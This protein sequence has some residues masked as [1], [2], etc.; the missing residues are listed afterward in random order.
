C[1]EVGLAARRRT[2][3]VTMTSLQHMRRLHSDRAR[4]SHD[5]IA[6]TIGK[7]ILAGIHA[8]GTNLPR[9]AV[10]LKRFSI[11]RTVL[12]EVMKTLSAKGLVVL[13]TR[14]GTRVLNSS[15][16]NLFDS[17]LLAWR[18]DMGLDDE[19]RRALTEI[20]LAVEPAAAALAARRR[21]EAQ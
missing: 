5:I 19:F 18:V 3:Q 2:R 16:W 11:S 17:D 14:I 6:R 13:K 15:S 1:R 10:L 4:S 9:E 8:P 20:R 21:T 12:R 7:Q